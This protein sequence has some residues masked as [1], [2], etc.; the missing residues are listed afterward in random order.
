MIS[1]DRCQNAT[2]SWILCL[3]LL[4]LV[5]LYLMNSLSYGKKSIVYLEFE[6]PRNLV[7]FSLLLRITRGTKSRGSG[8]STLRPS[9]SPTTGST[10]STRF[11]NFA[12]IVYFVIVLFYAWAP[13]Y[14]S[15]T[16]LFSLSLSLSLSVSFPLSFNNFGPVTSTTCIK[17]PHRQ[18]VTNTYVFVQGSIFLGWILYFI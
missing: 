6:N 16:N 15:L 10:T 7:S 18:I 1:C 4:V 14:T 12:F 5:S 2:L 17:V 9:T 3:C 8:W 13:W 11:N